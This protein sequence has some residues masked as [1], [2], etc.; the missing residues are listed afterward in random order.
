MK[1]LSFATLLA[2]ASIALALDGQF[3]IHDPSTVVI[4]DGKYYVWGT[5]GTPLVS[6]DG[7]TWR[8]GV[9]P[10]RRGAAPDVIHIGDK[11]FMYVVGGGAPNPSRLANKNSIVMLWNKTLYPDAPEY[12]WE[13]GG[14]VAASDGIEDCNAIDP[15]AFLDPKTGRLWLTYGS[16]VGYIRLVEL[17]P[18]TGKRKNPNNKPVDLAINCEASDMMYHDGWYYLLATHGSCCRGSESGY[19]IRMGRSRRVNGPFIDAMGVDMI[20]GGGKM[21]VGSGG[22]LIG[23]GHFGL[24]DLGQGVQKFSMHWEA[25]LDKGGG[26]VLDIR[27]LLWKDGW[28]VAGENAKEGTY[29]IE[30]ARTGTALEMAVEG[31]PVGGRRRG[32]GPIGGD[33][34]RA[35]GAPGGA[36]GAPSGAGRGGQGAARGEPPSEW[37]RWT[38]RWHVRRFRRADSQSGCQGGFG[39]LA[40]GHR[41]HTHGQLPVPGPGEVDHYTRTG[42]RRLPRL[43][44]F[45]DHRRRHG[46]GARGY[47]RRGIGCSFRFHRR[48]G[49]TVAARPTGGRLVADYAEGDSEFQ[50]SLGAIGGRQQ[51]CDAVEV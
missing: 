39:Q 37:A 25:D 46:P 14:T 48:A 23:P 1:F 24:L 4:C 36:V 3:G 5:G 45:Q 51:L 33:A 11:Y 28:P 50:G 27:P 44:V 32:R 21:L 17:D 16:Y 49:T 26:S 40:G 6:D 20:Q 2:L 9:R 34:G 19:N 22:R 30:S 43:A 15:G 47:R 10:P 35:P 7:W 8:A 42:R 38:G 41:Q 12:K 13:D 31:M 18:K 29:E